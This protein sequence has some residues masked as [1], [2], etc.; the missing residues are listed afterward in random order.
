MFK[1]LSGIYIVLRASSV[2][3]FARNFATQMNVPNFHANADATIFTL[4][5]EKAAESRSRQSNLLC[6]RITTIC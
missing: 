3:S 6:K 2:V 1:S 5:A 4:H